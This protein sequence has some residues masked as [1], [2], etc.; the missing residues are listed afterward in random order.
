MAFPVKSIMSTKRSIAD[1]LK[2]IQQL[3]A[4]MDDGGDDKGSD[5]I[6]TRFDVAN[7]VQPAKSEPK[8]DRKGSDVIPTRFDVA[9]AVQP[10]KSEKPQP[11]D[12]EEAEE[13]EVDEVDEV[14]GDMGFMDAIEAA[15]DKGKKKAARKQKR[16]QRRAAK[17]A[18][19]KE[20]FPAGMEEVE[21]PSASTDYA[22]MPADGSAVGYNE[23]PAEEVDMSDMMAAYRGEEVGLGIDPDEGAFDTTAG[24][25]KEAP[26]TPEQA[27]ELFK[28]AHGTSFDPKSSMDAK[29]MKE[30]EDTLKE[31]GGL[32]DQ[33]A[34]QFALNIYRKYKYV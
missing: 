10:A 19:G 17:K 12:I 26:Y 14:D 4:D 16:Q 7:A 15:M 5:V 3:M 11:E 21:S 27:Q 29:K 23:E 20:P 2:L 32:G 28:V 34:N 1:T 24:E 25:P 31:Q 33:S 9:N 13:A 8:K 18:S 6:P 30:I 22:G